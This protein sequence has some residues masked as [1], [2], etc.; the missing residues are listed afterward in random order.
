MII[1]SRL[2]RKVENKEKRIQ[3]SFD[4]AV[5]VM[6]SIPTIDMMTLFSNIGGVV[7]LTLGLSI[8]QALEGT[9]QLAKE[10]WRKIGTKKTKE[11]WS[12][13]QFSTQIVL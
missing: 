3:L 5:L 7:G 12:L 4:P 6:K 8:L 13:K 10:M 11:S 2:L 1:E 9:E